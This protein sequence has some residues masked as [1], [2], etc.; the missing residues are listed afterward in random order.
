M[1]L[2]VNKIATGHNA[3]DIAETILMNILRGDI[4]RLKRCTSIITGDESDENEASVI[5][6]CKPLKY[7][8]EKEIVLYAFYKRLDYFSTECL[9]SPNAYRG[10]IR[11]YIKDLERLR[12]SSIIDIIHSGEQLLIKQTTKMPVQR[13]CERCSYCSSMPVCKACLLIEGLNKGVPKLGIGKTERYRKEMQKKEESCSKSNS[14]KSTMMQCV[15]LVTLDGDTS[16]CH[17]TQEKLTVN[18]GDH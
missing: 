13:V 11:T 2:A 8:Y 7:A 17:C 9:Y 15:R 18:G 1:K 6:R 16:L 3:D 4:A 5:P 10:N 12:P 14:C